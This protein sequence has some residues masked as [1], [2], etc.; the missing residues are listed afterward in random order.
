MEGSPT[1]RHRR[2][3]SQHNHTRTRRPPGI[4]TTTHQQRQ[5]HRVNR[6][7]EGGAQMGHLQHHRF[8]PPTKLGE[9]LH[10]IL[11]HRASQRNL[12]L[13][14]DQHRRHRHLQRH[15]LRSNPQPDHN[16]AHTPPPRSNGLSEPNPTK[17]L[18]RNPHQHSARMG[19]AP[20]GAPGK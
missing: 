3:H 12:H 11:H 19:D 2:K 9:D 10:S 7:R 14:P 13:Q 16:T 17:R 6:L 15:S 4:L 5:L 18:R 20:S 1:Q 8:T